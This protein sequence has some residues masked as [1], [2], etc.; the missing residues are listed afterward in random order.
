MSQREE[1]LTVEE[2]AAEIRVHPDTVR[3]WIR[4]G[5]L[6]AVDIGRGYR[7]YRSDLNDFLERRK[8]GKKRKGDK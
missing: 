4:S 2:V 1:P 5:E 3:S 7:I 6:V 8:T